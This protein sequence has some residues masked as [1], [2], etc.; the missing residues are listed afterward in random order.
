MQPLGIYSGVL[1]SRI[2]PIII[3]R[4]YSVYLTFKATIYLAL[5]SRLGFWTSVGAVKP[6]LE[7]LA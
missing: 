4:L 5:W 1:E 7:L 3:A 6:L 2:W